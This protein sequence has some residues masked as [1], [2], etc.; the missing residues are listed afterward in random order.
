MSN[1]AKAVGVHPEDNTVRVRKVRLSAQDDQELE[2]IAK[3]YSC[4]YNRSPSLSK[5]LSRIASGHLSVSRSELPLAKRT[6]S[7]VPLIELEIEVLSNLNGTLAEIAKRIGDCNG[8]IYR[9]SAVE[10]SRNSNIKIALFIPKLLS[11]DSNLK[12]LVKSLYEITVE[13]VWKFNEKEKLETL[14]GVIDPVEKLKYEHQKNYE[15]HKEEKEKHNFKKN[16]HK[17]REHGPLKIEDYFDIRCHKIDNSN[18][19]NRKL[20]TK[21]ICT[22]GYQ[23]V[24]DNQPGT[25]AKLT[26]EIAEKHIS[27]SS[28]DIDFSIHEDKNLVALCLGFCPV[29]DEVS[30]RIETIQKFMADLDNL[31]FVESVKQLSVYHLN[32]EDK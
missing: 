14:L 11:K 5:L 28:I 4:T 9:A 1:M 19:R 20:V 7:T 3:R 17:D 6:V 30:P 12:K 13:H 23:I 32:G 24:I 27:I 15:Q 21:L 18:Y 25:L 26:R 2:K 16:Q 22:I 31:N 10:K 29:V 8:N